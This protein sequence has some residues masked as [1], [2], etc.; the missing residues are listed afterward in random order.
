VGLLPAIGEIR[1][2]IP[3]RRTEAD[4]MISRSK[5]RLFSPRSLAFGMPASVVPERRC[6]NRRSLRMH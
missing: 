3:L 1:V 5:A 4:D 2:R 6:D